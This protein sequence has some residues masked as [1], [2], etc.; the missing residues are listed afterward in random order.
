MGNYR[1]PDGIGEERLLFIRY[2]ALGDVVRAIPV[3]ATIKKTFPALHITWL[4]ERPF[5]ELIQG[6]SYVDDMLVWDRKLGLK[7]FWGLIQ[8]IRRSNF[9]HLV[10]IQGTDRSAVIALLSGIKNRA[11]RH[12]WASF[13]YNLPREDISQ[14]LGRPVTIDRSRVYYKIS[15]ELKSFRND[16]LCGIS[17]PRIACIIGASK[18]VKRWP[19][20][21]WAE[22][23]EMIVSMGGSPILIGHG[24]EEKNIA[25]EIM[26]TLTNGV[27][28]KIL[29]LVGKL[30]LNEMAAIIDGCNAIIGGDTG[31]MHLALALKRPTIGIFG[32]TLPEQVG[33]SEI[34]CKIMASCPLAG[35]QKW[36]CPNKCLSSIQPAEVFKALLRLCANTN[37]MSKTF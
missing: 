15:D 5:D 18:P 23:A 9:T 11:G 12:D 35:C 36:N 4:L 29:D 8:S 24:E 28:K 2:S 33:L 6:Q 22:L 26:S 27:Y 7:G 37:Y 16:L 17:F 14:I 3:V 25:R 13:V 10:S 20:C 21:N 34:N 19:A 31:P 30:K 1:P 32:P